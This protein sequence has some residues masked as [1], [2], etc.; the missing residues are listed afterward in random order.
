MTDQ[1]IALLEVFSANGVAALL[2]VL[3]DIDTDSELP[4]DQRRCDLP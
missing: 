1:T 3:S 4:P 2:Q